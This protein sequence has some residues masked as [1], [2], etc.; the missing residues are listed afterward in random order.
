[1]IGLLSCRG[2]PGQGMRNARDRFISQIWNSFGTHSWDFASNTCG[3]GLDGLKA[4]GY[5]PAGWRCKG[6]VVRGVNRQGCR[7]ALMALVIVLG[8]AGTAHGQADPWRADPQ[9]CVSASGSGGQCT[10]VKAGLGLWDVAFS[11]DPDRRNAYGISYA[12]SAVLIFDRNPITGRLTQR[13][14]GGCLS[15]TGN[16]GA[17]VKAKGLGNPADIIVS[18]DGEF[19]YVGSVNP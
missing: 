18:P 6:G 11:P 4:P 1:M 10:T 14:A 3:F 2:R 13:G 17:C 12:D 7:V 8:C 9:S 19:V 15:E 5:G 16:G